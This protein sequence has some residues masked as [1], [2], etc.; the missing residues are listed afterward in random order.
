M[1]LQRVFRFDRPRAIIQARATAEPMR[2]PWLALARLAC[3]AAILSTLAGILPATAQSGCGC[4]AIPAEGKYGA[5]QPLTL[6]YADG[7]ED[8]CPTAIHVTGPRPDAANVDVMLR[9]AGNSRW[10]GEEVTRV[11]IFTWRID[12]KPEV[13][14]VMD[15]R[16]HAALGAAQGLST[17]IDVTLGLPALIHAAGKADRTFT[18]S[19]ADPGAARAPPC[20]CERV[21]QELAFVTRYR[22]LYSSSELIADAEAQGMRGS[23]VSAKFWMDDNRVL[24]RFANASTPT[25]SFDDWIASMGQSEAAD[26][27]TEPGT[28]ASAAEAKAADPVSRGLKSGAYAQTHPIRCGIT[29]MPERDIR[30]RCEPQIV[31]FAAIK[32]EEQHMERCLRL[33]RPPTYS[34][35]DV[36]FNWQDDGDPNMGIYH[37]GDRLPSSGYYGWIQNPANAAADE[38]ASY[39]IEVGILTDYLASRCP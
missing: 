29:L 10:E 23:Q 36:A 14:K 21:R 28:V 34:I 17:T 33:N 35:G 24:H 2:L 3:A 38:A 8:S 27:S 18:L 32:H 6:A 26:P 12:P 5:S 19:L 25:Y 4:L 22:D 39:G 15:P 31:L 37:E 9:C 30:D 16:Q 7:D 20:V 11:G 13:P 1:N